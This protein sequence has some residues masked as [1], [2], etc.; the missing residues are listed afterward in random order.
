MCEHF[1]I[2]TISILLSPY[3]RVSCSVF[4]EGVGD[5]WGHMGRFGLL[6]GKIENVLASLMVIKLSK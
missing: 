3:Y 1:K 6:G 5:G 2:E 4:S